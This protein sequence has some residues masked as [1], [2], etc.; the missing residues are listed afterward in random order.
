[1]R[2]TSDTNELLPLTDAAN[3]AL[4]EYTK[5]IKEFATSSSWGATA[6]ALHLA[7]GPLGY[8][9]TLGFELCTPLDFP[10][11][12]V[13]TRGATKEQ[14]TLRAVAEWLQL[15]F[16]PALRIHFDLNEDH[17]RDGET[18]T[19]TGAGRHAV[20]WRMAVGSVMVQSEHL[21]DMGQLK[22][23]LAERALFDR[24]ELGDVLR[25]EHD[26]PVM[27]VKMQ[28]WR[29]AGEKMETVYT[30]M[31]NNEEWEAGLERLKRFELP[32]GNTSMM[33]RQYL[34]VK[35]RRRRR[36]R[37]RR[38]PVGCMWRRGRRGWGWRRG[39]RGWG[40]RGRRKGRRRWG[41]W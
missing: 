40:W 29:P 31:V 33:V 15:F 21:T 23:E 39:G 7:E 12:D 6:V 13:V 19:G 26:V 4:G 22:A 8:D 18:M 37:G 20:H 10:L 30:C 28:L 36:R 25:F 1:M 2:E 11:Q 34:F 17:M 27:C 24:V 9:V 32:A 16:K 5:K 14:A 41:W 38:G 3:Q 35:R